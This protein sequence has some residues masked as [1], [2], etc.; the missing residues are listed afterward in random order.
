LVPAQAL[1]Q[2]LVRERALELAPALA[3]ARE[4][5]LAPVQ[6]LALLLQLLQ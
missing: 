2:G 3:Q 6:A 4:S 5:V 1:A